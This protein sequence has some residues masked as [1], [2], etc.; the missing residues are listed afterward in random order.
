MKILFLLIILIQGLVQPKMGS[1]L[2]TKLDGKPGYIERDKKLKATVIYFLSPECPLCQSYSVNI[3][4][5]AAKYQ[6]KGIRFIAIVPGTDFNAN[7]ILLFRI[8]YKLQS[9][10]FYI[11]PKL[12]MVHLLKASI[13]P[14]VFVLD[15]NENLIYSGRIDNWAYELSRKR[16][17]I[18]EHDLE[19]VL[20]AVDMNA[21]IK[22]RKTKAVGCF[23]E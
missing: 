18:T 23:I 4:S 7:E 5:L 8:K 17:V 16:K 14:E 10:S 1:V 11:D 19:N 2:L 12:E 20:A 13:T 9:I 3:K 6:N 22:Y 21:K 15:Q